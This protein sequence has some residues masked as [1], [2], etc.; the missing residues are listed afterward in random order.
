MKVLL[1]SNYEELYAEDGK[2][3]LVSLKNYI[4]KANMVKRDMSERKLIPDTKSIASKK[5]SEKFLIQDVKTTMRNLQSALKTDIKKLSDDEVREKKSGLLK[6]IG[7]TENLSKMVHNLLECSNSVAKDE[8]DEVMSNYNNISHLKEEY[9][10]EV[11][12]R[13]ITKQK[14]FNE[15]KLRINLSKFYGY[16]S[17]LDIYSFQSEFLRIYERTT[18]KHRVST[19]PRN[20]GNVLE[21]VLEITICPGNF[22]KCPRILF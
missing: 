5:R 11:K 15:S 9:V 7:K 12:N 16:E 2:K 10:Y 21:F 20:P 19:H 14:L 17:K 22:P 6:L 8:V 4:I 18:L 3:R 13:E 1:G